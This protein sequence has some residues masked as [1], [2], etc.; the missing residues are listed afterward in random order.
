MC[1]QVPGAWRRGR[2]QLTAT[3]SLKN[4]LENAAETGSGG[5]VGRTPTFADDAVAQVAWGEPPPC[6]VRDTAPPER[7]VLPPRSQEAMPGGRLAKPN[8]QTGFTFSQACLCQ[9]VDCKQRFAAWKL[10]RA[11]LFLLSLSQA[12]SFML[13]LSFPLCIFHS[14]SHSCSLAHS[15]FSWLYF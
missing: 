15:H 7:G 2:Q 8:S 10:G 13:P 9:S 6:P 4:T 12:L 14:R 1:M 3:G 11:G 5:K